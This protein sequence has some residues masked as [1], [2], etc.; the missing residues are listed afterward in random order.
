MK[1]I[2]KITLLTLVTVATLNAV[3]AYQG[4]ITFTQN[5]G[6]TFVGKLKG[7]EYFHWIEDKHGNLIVYNKKSQRYELGKVV[8]KEGKLELEATGVPLKRVQKRS[9]SAT[10]HN[11]TKRLID[12]D[13]LRK[14]WQRKREE[15]AKRRAKMSEL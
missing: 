14:I 12:G 8:E 2:T 5:D 3:E 6:T 9:L 11:N 1:W 10:L 4:D 15:A 13:V 7:D